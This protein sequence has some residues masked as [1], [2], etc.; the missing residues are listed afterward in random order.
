MII[1]VEF[2]K[3]R[4]H[5]IM[6]F[7]DNSMFSE[8]VIYYSHKAGIDLYKDDPKFIFKSKEIKANSYKTLAELGITNNSRID[9]VLKNKAIPGLALNPEELFPQVNNNLFAKNQLFNNPGSYNK[10]KE[11]NQRLKEELN[12]YKND[13]TILNNEINEYKNENKKLKEEIN[14][15]KCINEQLKNEI[16]NLTDINN[17]QNKEISKANKII[18]NYNQLNE[19]IKKK[20]REIDNLAIQLSNI[21]MNSKKLVE[22]DNIMVVNFISSD[23]KINCGIKCLSS[24]T[25]AE[26]EEQLYQ[27]YEEFRE[28]NNNFIA[29]GKMILRFKTIL[30]NGI[31]NGNKIQLINLE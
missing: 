7:I 14:T 24:N 30:E 2:R 26:V 10:Y 23:Q 31:K 29:N 20:N 19:T 15:Y 9:V 22:F 16:N 3:E 12:I 21:K 6:Q 5:S 11:E 1:N 4:E 13:N 27:Q 8:V 25:F 28:R 18:S 17:I